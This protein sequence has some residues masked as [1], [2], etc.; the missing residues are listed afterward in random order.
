GDFRYRHM[1]LPF[2]KK[3]RCVLLMADEALYVFRALP[4]NVSLLDTVP[5]QE[6]D[7]ED[8]VS[9]YITRECRA[10]PVLL[11]NDMT[12]QHFK[13]GQRLPRVG[14]MDKGAV[15]KRK[16]RVTF[17]NYPIRGALPVKAVK[18]PKGQE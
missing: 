7:F 16:L 14:L 6:P 5:W 1:A 8:I 9:G 13:G 2:L 3:T 4:G 18:P 11:V 10:K 17:P 12:D 15:L